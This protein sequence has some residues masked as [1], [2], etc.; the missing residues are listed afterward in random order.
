M[1]DD[2]PV[3]LT[4][5]SPST[6]VTHALRLP[7]NI[8]VLGTVFLR[9]VGN[10]TRVGGGIVGHGWRGRRDLRRWQ[11]RH[12]EHVSLGERIGNGELKSV[13]PVRQIEFEISDGIVERLKDENVADGLARFD[14]GERV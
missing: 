8:A 12:R 10:Q 6:V 5:E 14:E 4:P 1:T 2:L 9:N 3:S 7:F 11:G 13:P